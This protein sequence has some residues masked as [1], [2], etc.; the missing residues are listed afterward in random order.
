VYDI[1]IVGA[2]TAGLSAAIYGVRA[3][4]S[5]LVLENM[6]Y[7][8]QIINALHVQNYP[9]IPTVSGF[10]F[11]TALYDQALALGA[12]I[13]LQEV[14]GIDNSGMYTKVFAGDTTFECRSL[15]IATGAKNRPLGIEDENRLIGLGISYCATCDGAFYKGMDVAVVGG[16]N[17]AV[18]DALFLSSY[19]SK[20]YLIHRRREFRAEPK[21][22][23]LLRAK[24]NV[25]LVLDSGVTKLHGQTKLESITVHNTADNSEREIAVAGLFVAIGQSP[26]NAPFAPL[27]A[28]DDYGYVVAG[29]DCKTN[30]PGIFAAGD[31]RT[32]TVRQLVTAAADGAVAAIA[33]AEYIK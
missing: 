22:I 26:A 25:E 7:G 23:S 9:G 27:V 28:L 11:A 6:T 12:E 4:L 33:A 8:G 32:K 1:I 16:G 10:D 21:E 19:C 18:E 14:T 17:T 30:V 31:C 2:G 24:P 15:I 13:Q 5:V 29:E 3:G 20:V